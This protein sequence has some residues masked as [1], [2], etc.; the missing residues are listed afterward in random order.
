M[1]C[2]VKTNKINFERKKEKDHFLLLLCV[3]VELSKSTKFSM[4]VVFSAC[5]TQINLFELKR[6]LALM[7][8]I[9]KNM[10]SC[11]IKQH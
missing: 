3:H 7:H 8:I 1:M 6:L 9:Q 4:R 2:I 5:A 10:R 11:I